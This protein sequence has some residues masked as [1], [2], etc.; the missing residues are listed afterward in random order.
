M[1]R[2][3]AALGLVAAVVLVGGCGLGPGRGAQD[4]RVTVSQDFGAGELGTAKR[5]TPGADTVL[6]L[7]QRSFRVKQHGGFVDAIDGRAGGR[8]AGRPFD[9]FYYVNGVEAPVGS[10]A[11]PARAGDRIR[12]DLHDWGAAMDAP[13]IVA[14]F[15]EPFLHGVDGKR[16]PTRLECAPDVPLACARADRRLG[17]AGALFAR[18]AF[19]T[20][21]GKATLRILVGTWRDVRA[22]TAARQLERGVRVSGVYVK[23]SPSGTSFGVLDARGQT[24]DE[25]GPGTGL[26]AAVRFEGSAPLWLVTGTDETGVRAA[27]EHLS[28]D[29]LHGKWAALVSGDKVT[30]AP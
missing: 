28:V 22:S 15:P 3:I 16:Y 30:A 27:A 6:R 26:I 20:A 11:T 13:A 4:V 21:A 24:V 19:G 2:R 18:S 25:R 23:P 1:R 8:R 29:D 9:W 17:E 5:D 12:W 7:L 14:D 10:A